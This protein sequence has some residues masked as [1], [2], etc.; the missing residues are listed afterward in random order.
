MRKIIVFF[1]I[2]PSTA[3]ILRVLSTADI[4]PQQRAWFEAELCRL[5]EVDRFPSPLRR[6]IFGYL[7]ELHPMTLEQAKVF[8]TQLMAERKFL[9]D[10]LTEAVFERPF[11][12]CE[13]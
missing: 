4:P 11:S 12:L 13:H 8:R 3:T 7:D 2:Q 10:Q 1:L 5:P 9:R 6:I